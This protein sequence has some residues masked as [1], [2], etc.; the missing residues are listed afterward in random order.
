MP[1]LAL[2]PGHDCIQGVGFVYSLSEDSRPSRVGVVTCHRYGFLFVSCFSSC[3]GVALGEF[4]YLNDFVL[5][6]DSLKFQV[7]FMILFE[8]FF[9]FLLQLTGLMLPVSLVFVL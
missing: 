3:C 1:E 7:A 5:F 9:F 2:E 8:H 6:L 4:G